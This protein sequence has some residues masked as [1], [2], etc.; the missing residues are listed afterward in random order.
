MVVVVDMAVLQWMRV[1]VE[2]SNSFHT[3]V[4]MRVTCP[5]S[6][7][8]ADGQIAD[9]VASSWRARVTKRAGLSGPGW[10]VMMRPLPSMN[11]A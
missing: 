4:A 7:G 9:Q 3:G 11:T 10:M 8:R 5:T 6:N 2:N 1:R